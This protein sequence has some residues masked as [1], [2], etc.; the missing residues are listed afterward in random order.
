MVPVTAPPGDAADP[1]PAMTAG[2]FTSVPSVPPPVGFLPSLASGSRPLTRAA[3]PLLREREP[4]G[5]G[6][7][8]RA[9]V[10]RDRARWDTPHHLAPARTDCQA[11]GANPAGD[12]WSVTGLVR[13]L[14]ARRRSAPVLFLHGGSGTGVRQHAHAA[15]DTNT[16]AT[17]AD[18]ASGDPQPG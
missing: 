1:P 2:T 16:H 9:S 4:A 3:G 13:H 18:S 6:H 7:V 5:Q 8:C 14:A 11:A 12:H 17:A 15:V 10:S